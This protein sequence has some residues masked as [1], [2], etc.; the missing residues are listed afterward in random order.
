MYSLATQDTNANMTAKEA[1]DAAMK[2][3][4][5]AEQAEAFS[6]KAIRVRNEPRA[7]SKIKNDYYM[8]KC[9]S[10]VYAKLKQ[11]NAPKVSDFERLFNAFEKKWAEDTGIP[12]FVKWSIDEASPPSTRM[13]MALSRY[14]Y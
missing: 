8:S 4:A 2:E 6:A 11:I 1:K 13:L 9:D 5:E 14:T 3:Q 7:E 12:P 10:N